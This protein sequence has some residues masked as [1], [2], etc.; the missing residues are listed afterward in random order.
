MTRRARCV[1]SSPGPSLVTAGRGA[2]APHASLVIDHSLR[3][4]LANAAIAASR[5]LV[6]ALHWPTVTCFSPLF[7]DAIPK[8]EAEEDWSRERWR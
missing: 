8:T 5:A 1:V 6:L 7:G 3:Q 4:L 2:S